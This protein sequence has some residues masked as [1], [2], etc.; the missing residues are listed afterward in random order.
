MVKIPKDN[1]EIKKS[2]KKI[3][4]DKSDTEITTVN[5]LEN[6][7]D[8]ELEDSHKKNNKL[9][10]DICQ[11]KS[12]KNYFSGGKICV[13]NKDTLICLL[14]GTIVFFNKKENSIILTIQYVY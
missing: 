6:E 11:Y 1:K 4:K 10:K 8:N 3:K 14:N 5:L 2:S 13:Y 9:I 7:E 12:I